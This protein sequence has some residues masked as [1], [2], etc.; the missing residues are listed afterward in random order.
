VT[1][2]HKSKGW[3]GELGYTYYGELESANHLIFQ[4]PVSNFQWCVTE[5]LGWSRRPE[6]FDDLMSISMCKPGDSSNY[7]G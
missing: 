7:I 5:A 1:M 6:S 2:D 3:H 4:C